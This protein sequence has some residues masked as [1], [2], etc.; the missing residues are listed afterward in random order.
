MHSTFLVLLKQPWGKSQGESYGWIFQ[1]SD[2]PIAD[3]RFNH[4]KAELVIS[5]KRHVI[6]RDLSINSAASISPNL[7]LKA[8]YISI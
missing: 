1:A 8:N 2:P 5:V 3:V 7:V 4:D 6:G